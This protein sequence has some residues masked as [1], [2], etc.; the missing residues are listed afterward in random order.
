MKNIYLY[1]YVIIGP[2][3]TGNMKL[4]GGDKQEGRY[5]LKK[6]LYFTGHLFLSVGWERKKY[7]PIKKYKSK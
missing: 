6:K 1:I 2:G 7:T 4:L 5:S 3:L